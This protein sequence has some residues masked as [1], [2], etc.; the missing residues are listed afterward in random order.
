[1][2]NEIYEDY[3]KKKLLTNKRKRNNSKNKDDFD[4]DDDDNAFDE[5][6]DE[7]KSDENE[8]QKI[9][10]SL[11]EYELKRALKR[12]EEYEY[13]KL[14]LRLSGESC[15]RKMDNIIRNDRIKKD[16]DNSMQIEEGKEKPK[17][18]LNT[19]HLSNKIPHEDIDEIDEDEIKKEL[20]K[21][22]LIGAFVGNNKF[23]QNIVKEVFREHT[24]TDLDLLIKILI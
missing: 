18:I 11:D 12:E 14:G 6:Y 20:R 10:D 24:T 19:A 16:G 22:P 23:W 2:F 3:Q 7:E 17:K 8:E 5:W 13:F 15:T 9:D 1:M 21:Y 4:F